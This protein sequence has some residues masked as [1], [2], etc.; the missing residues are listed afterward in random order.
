M[1]QKFNNEHHS[2]S[3]HKKTAADKAYLTLNFSKLKIVSNGGATVGYVVSALGLIATP[4]AVYQLSD[5]TVL[6]AFWYFPANR[7]IYQG[8]LSPSLEGGKGVPQPFMVESGALFRN[9]EKRLEATKTNFEKQ[10][11][12]TLLKLEKQIQSH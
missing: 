5:Q 9:K 7:F 2:F 6:L 4:L 8:S 12:K 10:L 3:V 1:I 11:Y